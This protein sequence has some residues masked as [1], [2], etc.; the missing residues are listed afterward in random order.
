MLLRRGDSWRSLFR[1][2]LFLL[3]I[4][5]L[6]LSISFRAACADSSLQKVHI[7]FLYYDRFCQYCPESVEDYIVY[8]HNR[9]VLVRIAED[10]GEKVVV[11]HIF[12][13]SEEG[14]KKVKQ[15]GLSLRDW[16]AIV[17]NGKVISRGRERVDE[18]LLR[19]VVDSCLTKLGEGE[20]SK[21]TGYEG[22]GIM[23]TAFVLGFFESFSPCVLIML[24]FII[25]F[26]LSEKELRAREGFLRVMVFG[27]SFILAS[28]VLSYLCSSLVLFASAIRLHI[29]IATFVLATLFGLDLL[30]LLRFSEWSKP[31]IRRVAE[32]Y[33]LNYVK[34]FLLG[35]IFYFLDP[36]VAPIF[37]SMVAVLFSESLNLAVLLFCIGAFL[38]FIMAGL[39]IESL[40]KISRKVYR[41]RIIVRGVSGIILIGCATYLLYH[42]IVGL[43]I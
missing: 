12:F 29:N 15:Y 19:E 13:F 33:A 28:L 3:C 10:Y 11:N 6:L 17:V 26:I 7:D 35:F 20:L 23:T 1:R 38:P 14:L 37:A 9:E 18:A 24:S 43:L 36:C 32:K 39:L 8:V 27:S 34:I 4:V 2:L 21:L 22:I 42:V 5:A 16:N 40:S 25:G 30:G 41:H 31:V